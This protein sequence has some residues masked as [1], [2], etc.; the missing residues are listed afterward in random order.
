MPY[1]D[2]FRHSVRIDEQ[3]T[4]PIFKVPG[5]SRDDYDACFVSYQ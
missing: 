3:L 1:V 5:L 4:S 2:S